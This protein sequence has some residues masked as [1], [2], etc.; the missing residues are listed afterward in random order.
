MNRFIVPLT[1]L[2]S[3]NSF[4]ATISDVIIRQQWP[5]DAKVNVDYVISDTQGAPQRISVKAYDGDDFLCT[6]PVN[7]LSGDVF[8]SSNGAKRI[9]LNPAEVSNLAE[10]GVVKHFRVELVTSDMPLYVIVD[11]TKAA[12]TTGQISY[13]SGEDLAT[14]AYGPTETNKWASNGVPAGGIIWTGVTND[15][16]YA[17]T[18]LVLRYCPSGDFTMGATAAEYDFMEPWMNG[19]EPSHHVSL[20]KAFFIG[21]FPITQGQW[22]TIMGSVPDNQGGIEPMA[23]C[24]VNQVSYEDIRGSVKGAMWP[25]SN[26]VDSVAFLGRLQE[27]TGIPLDLPTDA[28]WEYACRAHSTSSW[29]NGMMITAKDVD[30]QLDLLGWYGHNSEGKLHPVG[31]K[32]ANA[33]GLYDMHGNVWEW[34]LDWYGDSLT[35]GENPT[36]DATG[37]YR[38]RRGGRDYAL[39]QFCRASYRDADIP[40]SLGDSIGARVCWPLR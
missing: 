25:T 22:R 4:S 38:V 26:L 8:P 24:P 35:D 7:A 1:L 17:T 2:V 6:I 40:S 12:G 11:L 10:L 31:Q 5:W 36:G 21:V 32:L 33:W 29:N 28:Q 27:K 15:S 34:C 14:G 39:A 13:L 19:R 30:A 9:I 20:R 37:M 18:K 16:V 3:L 23:Q